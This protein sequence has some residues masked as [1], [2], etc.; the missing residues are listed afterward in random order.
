MNIMKKKNVLWV[1]ATSVLMVSSSGIFGQNANEIMKQ[2]DTRTV[3]KD[4]KTFMKMNLIDAKNQVRQR[5]LKTYMLSDEKMMMWFLSPADVKGSS[6]L[7]V[8]HDDKDDDM[9]IYLP[10]LGKVR[11]IA[12]S[13]TNGSFMG[14]D[15]SFEDMGERKL[16]DYSYKLLKE[17]TV[18]GK[19]CWVIECIPVTG[20]STDYSKIISWVWKDEYIQIREEL[21]NKKAILKKVKTSEYTKIKT[22]WV[23]KRFLMEDISANHKT[24]ML[25]D[26]I[27]VDTGID[28]AIF[29]QNNLTKIY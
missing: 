25:F 17:E 23:P 21:Y 12:S 5:D 22:Y 9:W 15:F 1:I 24:E 14:S 16:Q 3:P 8:S 20:V 6:F 4:T 27:E 2:V 11:R 10:A 19:S 13:A 18:A 28:P 29:D 7:R 26:K